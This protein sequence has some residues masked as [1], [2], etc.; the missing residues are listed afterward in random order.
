MTNTC[1]QPRRAGR[2]ALIA[3]T[4]SIVFGLARAGEV[5]RWVDDSGQV[6]FSDTLPAGVKAQRVPVGDLSIIPSTIPRDST[7]EAEPSP[8][9][10]PEEEAAA[11][12]YAERRQR[13]M[14]DCERNNG[15]E[16]EREV[17]TE[18]GAEAIQSSGRVIHLM[19]PAG[20]PL[21]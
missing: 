2:L 1:R 5:Y 15:T 16:C 4:L 19:R 7:P 13:M 12:A 20:G 17:D 11:Q 21:R 14:E 10:D 3:L 6:H 8:S 18:L 9:E